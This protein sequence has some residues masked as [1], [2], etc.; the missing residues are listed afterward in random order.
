M[1]SHSPSK[2]PGRPGPDRADCAAGSSGNAAWAWA[3]IALGAIAGAGPPRRRRP[4]PLAPKAPHFAPKAKRV[5]YL[6]MAGGPSHLELFDHKPRAGEMGRQAPAG[7]VAQ[8]LPRRLHQ[9]QARRCSGRSSSSHGTGQSGAEISELL[10][11]LAT[12]ADDIAIVKSMVTDAFNH[13]PAQIFMNTGS[14][15]FG[16]PSMGAWATYG[17]GSES[18]DLPGFVVFSTGTKGTSGGSS[19]WG[20][21]FLPTVYQGVP[22]RTSGDPVL[23]SRTRAGSTRPCSATRSTRSRRLNRACAWGSSATRRSPR[24]STRSRWPSGCNRAPPS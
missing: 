5:I 8:G 13:A 22:F 11:H 14:Q 3:A 10:P 24:G 4:I 6:F 1:R 17:L 20:S 15:Q 9:A 12:V 2:T 16:R 21:G 18:Q 19:N 7:G 23:I